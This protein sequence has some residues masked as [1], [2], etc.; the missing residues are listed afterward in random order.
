MWFS[1]RPQLTYNRIFNF[2]VGVRGGGKTF[3]TLR[4]AVETAIKGKGEFVYLRRS[5]VDIDDSCAGR[6]GQGDLFSPFLKEGYF[7]DAEL[8]IKRAKGGSY[9]FYAGENVI[10]Y[11]M[12]LSTARR[13]T[14]RPNVRLIIFDEFLIDDSRSSHHRY[15]PGEVNQ[16]Y[17]F[18]ET[19]ARGRDVPVFFLGNA[20][21]M[22]NPYFLDLGIR[23]NEP[24]S[25]KIY[26]GK[27]WTVVFWKDEAFLTNRRKTQFFQATSGTEFSAHSFDNSFY[28]DRKDFLR[29]KSNDAEHQFSLVYRGS[30]YGVWVDWDKGC[31][32]ISTKGAATEKEKTISLTLEDNQPNNINIRRYRNMPFMKAFRMA[33]DQNMVY[34]DKQETYNLMSEAVYLLKTIT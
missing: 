15:L 17:H 34:Y 5:Q 13:S 33:I 23:I 18:I 16:L 6:K 27:F 2:A 24:E 10:G 12:A 32:Y 25:N 22:V 20:F 14:P 8:S 31:Y 30:V 26:K 3:N 28:L 7:K 21:S 4:E 9:N 19:I 11:G 29:Q 1:S